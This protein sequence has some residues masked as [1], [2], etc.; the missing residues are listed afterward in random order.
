MLLEAQGQDLL[1]RDV[2]RIGWRLDRMT[3]GLS[4]AS[5][6]GGTGTIESGI[7]TCIIPSLAVAE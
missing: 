2:A 4:G 7:L 1:C 6:M 5:A 3:I